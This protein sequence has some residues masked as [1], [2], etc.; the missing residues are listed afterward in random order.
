MKPTY[1]PHID[2]LRAL[3]VVVVILYHCELKFSGRSLFGGGF[4]GV[5][6]FFVISGY[7]ITLSILSQ[8]YSNTFNLRGFYE[9]RARRILPALYLTILLSL[10]VAKF[11]LAKESMSDFAK[12]SLFAIGFNSNWWFVSNGSYVDPPTP[13]HPLLHTWTLSVEEQY[14]LLFPI[15][16]LSIWKLKPSW[17]LPIVALLCSFSFLTANIGINFFPP[18]NYYLFPSRAWEILCGSLLAIKESNSVVKKRPP[19]GDFL[20]VVGL[21]FIIYAVFAFSDQTP[22]PSSFT[23]LPIVGSMLVIRYFQ[24]SSIGALLLNNAF[25]VFIGKISYSLYLLHYPI[26]AFAKYQNGPLTTFQKIG[27]CVASVAAS[28]IFY[29]Y[30]EQPFRDHEAIPKK[31]FL[32]VAGMLTFFL[33]LLSWTFL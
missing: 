22:H 23:L 26:L 18:E 32:K 14:Y 25:V 5:E 13:T 29:F 12:S 1:K 19:F 21:I 27:C 15:L 2:G 6:V 7:L 11:T 17:T 30:I 31:M 9:K 20:P 28:I 24:P 4:V 16:V 3:A 33:L 10:I 8:L